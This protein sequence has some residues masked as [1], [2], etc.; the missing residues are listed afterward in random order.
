MSFKC[1]VCYIL[2]GQLIGGIWHAKLSK[3]SSGTE[4]EVDFDWQA[5]LVREEKR[6]D[7]IGFFHT[8]P[9]GIPEPSS[10]DRKTMSAWTISFGKP[11]LC[12]IQADNRL[13]AW[14]FDHRKEAAEP[15]KRIQRFKSGYLVALT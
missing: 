13:N 8:H 5:A 4:V 15:L 2:T 3:R 7:V 11:L 1:E 10:R 14:V 12:V 9:D 6:G